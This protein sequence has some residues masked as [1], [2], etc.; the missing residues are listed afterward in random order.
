MVIA[1]RR[2]ISFTSIT[3]PSPRMIISGAAI[4]ASRTLCLGHV[5]G[6]DHARQDAGV[7]HRGAGA[8]RRGRRAWR[9]RGRRS[10][11][12]RARR[13]VADRLLVRAVVDAEGAGGDDHLR[14]LLLQRAHGSMAVGLVQRL[15][16]DE[17]MAG[18]KRAAGRESIRR[19]GSAWR[20]APRPARLRWRRC[21]PAP[22]RLRAARWSP[23]SSN[24]RGT[25]RPRARPGIL[26]A[27]GGRPR[28]RRPQRRAGRRGWSA[29]N[30]G[31]RSRGCRRRPAPPW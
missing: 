10:P 6:L 18:M 24:G 3:P 21:R 5:G 4:P 30:S 27:R 13:G 20:R 31:R 8:R 16:L 7:D 12:G 9:S 1:G 29:S 14:A 28:P 2:R 11:A 15:A 17:A 19:C 26:R 22:R 25:R 23:A